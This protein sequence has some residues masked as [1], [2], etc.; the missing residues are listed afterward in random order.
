MTRDY[1][2][3]AGGLLLFI[4][5]LSF[6]LYTVLRYEM[7]T[8]RQ[9]GPGLMPAVLGMILAGLGAV[10]IIPAL[11]RAGAVP[12]IRIRSPLFVL[13]GVSAFAL[14]I[15]WVGLVPAIVATTVISSIADSEIRP[16]SI[17]ILSVFLCIAA[18]LV[19]K[20]GLGLPITMLRWPF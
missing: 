19:F 12:E 9:M 17:A 16:V 15:R 18:W 5:G 8:M 7:G 4:G 1:R 13:L 2:D 14:L 6:A 3:I 20:I 10:M 11:R